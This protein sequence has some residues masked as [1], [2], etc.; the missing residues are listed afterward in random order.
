MKFDPLIDILGALTYVLYYMLPLG[1]FFAD[2]SSREEQLSPH[3]T[4]RRRIQTKQGSATKRD[5]T[6][7]LFSYLPIPEHL[8]L[9]RILKYVA[10]RPQILEIKSL[11]CIVSLRNLELNSQIQIT[12]SRKRK[13]IGK[14]RETLFY[15]KTL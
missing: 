3:Q 10:V 9:P 2:E 11:R 15:R 4:I 12:L 5:Y 1:S 7:L 6:N 14:Q 13:Y 8:V